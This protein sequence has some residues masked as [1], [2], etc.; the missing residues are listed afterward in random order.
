MQVSDRRA[1]G[2]KGAFLTV[3]NS[4]G[5]FRQPGT[6]RLSTGNLA[7]MWLIVNSAWKFPGN[8]SSTRGSV[9]SEKC[10]E[11]LMR[12]LPSLTSENCGVAPLYTEC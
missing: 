9:S 7:F 2:G 8:H 3:Y 5:T 10:F 6:F 1:G 4:L 11:F 12:G